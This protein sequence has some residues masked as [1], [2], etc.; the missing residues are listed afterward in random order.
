[1][2]FAPGGLTAAAFVRLS[3]WGDWMG[4]LVACHEVYDNREEEVRTAAR[5]NNLKEKLTFFASVALMP[6][7]VNYSQ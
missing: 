3:S 5:E 2:P 6:I 4:S 1:M 7:I